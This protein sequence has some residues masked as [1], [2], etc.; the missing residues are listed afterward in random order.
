[1]NTVKR[2]MIDVVIENVLM[3]MY[4]SYRFL[5]GRFGKKVLRQPYKR[6][7]QIIAWSLFTYF[8][9]TKI[10]FPII[11]WWQSIVSYMNCVIWG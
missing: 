3:V 8:F 6:I 1:M 2:F 9:I 11:E 7:W 4:Y 5:N 10:T